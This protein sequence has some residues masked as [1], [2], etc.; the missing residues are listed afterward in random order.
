MILFLRSA[1]I[2]L[3]GD[4]RG[5]FSFILEIFYLL[6]IFF[7]QIIGPYKTMNF[8]GGKQ[9]VRCDFNLNTKRGKRWVVEKPYDKV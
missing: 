9:F 1:R 4:F 8:Y 6:V 5:N 2:L 3:N 7:I